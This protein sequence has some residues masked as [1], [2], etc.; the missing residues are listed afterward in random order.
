MEPTAS[1]SAP[2]RSKL[3]TVTAWLF[4]V[5]GAFTTTASLIQGLMYVRMLTMPTMHQ[6]MHEGASHLPFLLQLLFEHFRLYLLFIFSLS[7]TTLLSA[8]GLLKRNDL[9]RRTFITVLIIAVLAMLTAFITQ[10][11]ISP[12]TDNIPAAQIPGEAK[13]MMRAMKGFFFI[14]T[15]SVTCLAGW[16]MLQ[17]S[18]PEIKEEFTKD[19]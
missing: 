8:I 13:N 17:L 18:A 7:L 19:V 1:H 16:L 3:V 10:L 14:I 6:A 15:F 11:S 12:A 4:I 2:K 5:I 9:A